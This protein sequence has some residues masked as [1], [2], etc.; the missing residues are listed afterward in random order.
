VSATNFLV[1][2]TSTDLTGDPNTLLAGETLRYTITV[3]NTSS[4]N[5]AN[6]VLRDAVPANTTYVAGSTKLNGASVADV[7]GA[8]PDI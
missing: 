4:S 1:Q 3:R 7:A 8:S 5:A 2:K 6:V